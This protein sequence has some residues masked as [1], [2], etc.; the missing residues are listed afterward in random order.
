MQWKLKSPGDFPANW[1][2]L[3]LQGPGEYYLCYEKDAGCA[4]AKADKFRHFRYCLR[5]F[6]GYPA[7][8][9]ERDLVIKLKTRKNDEGYFE[10]WV[11]IKP[12]F[13]FSE[14]KKV[15]AKLGEKIY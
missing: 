11:I 3:L 8:A 13:D 12:H 9:T 6:P 7:S 4:R 1:H 15:L 14:T 10:I 5:H 2:S